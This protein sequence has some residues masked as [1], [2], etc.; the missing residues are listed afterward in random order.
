MSAAPLLHLQDMLHYDR[1]HGV[2]RV[3]DLRDGTFTELRDTEAV[4]QALTAGAR[5]GVLADLMAGCGLALAARAWQARPS[6][7]RMAAIIQAGERLRHAR[8]SA[9]LER[10]L[11]EALQR[12]DAAILAGANAEHAVADVVDAATQH[13]D[14][15]AERC[16]RRAAELLDS[17]DRVLLIGFVGAPLWMLHAAREQGKQLHLSVPATSARQFITQQARLLDITA[18]SL[19][20]DTFGELNL[21]IAAAEQIARDGSVVCHA[22]TQQ[23]AA[24]ARRHSVPFYVLGAAGPDAEADGGAALLVA[25]PQELLLPELVSAIITDRGIYRPAMITRYFDD[26]DAPLDVIPLV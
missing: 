5:D 16:G 6:E 10:L 11:A 25:P 8:P 23:H 12:A 26:G 18:E 3:L 24:Q 14:R 9:A 7:A 20:D 15:A 19:T 4:A 17:G 2:A 13:A 22:G 21:C 1:E